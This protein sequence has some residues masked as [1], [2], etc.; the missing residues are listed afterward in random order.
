[1]TPAPFQ[2]CFQKAGIPYHLCTHLNNIN[3]Q[4][5]AFPVEKR[6]C[7]PSSFLSVQLFLQ[8]SRINAYKLII[9]EKCV[10]IMK[11]KE[12]IISLPQMIS[13]VQEGICHWAG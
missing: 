10:D 7:F 3:L 6:V 12:R 4:K 13:L 9:V 5:K 2:P 8:F 11:R 1:M